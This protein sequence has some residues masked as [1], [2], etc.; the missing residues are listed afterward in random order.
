MI[1]CL[2]IAVLE[3]RLSL[4]YNNSCSIV[5]CVIEP[6]NTGLNKEFEFLLSID[7]LKE[8]IIEY[9]LTR[10]DEVEENHGRIRIIDHEFDIEESTLFYMKVKY[11][12]SFDCLV[13]IDHDENIQ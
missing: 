1:V 9:C 13:K 5:N 6:W 2:D 11:P 4:Y 10:I 12:N 7:N 8:N 3:P